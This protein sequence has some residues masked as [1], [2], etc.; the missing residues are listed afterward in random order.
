MVY[1]QGGNFSTNGCNSSGLNASGLCNPHGIAFDPFGNLYIA[2]T[3]NNRVVEYIAPLAG[4]TAAARVFGQ[5]GDFT[6]SDCNFGGQTPDAYSLCSPTQV[7]LDS[8]GD[9]Y[10]AD[11]GN[12]RV[13]EYDIPVPTSTRTPTPTPA[14]S[15]TRA[16][17]RTA[18]HTPTR[19][20]T[21]TPT[22]TTTHTA[23][24]T[25]THTATRTPTLSRTPT[26][27]ATPK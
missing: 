13:T 9:V 21:H 22:R 14:D 6:I 19:T 8:T 20:A 26:P 1:G 4:N 3:G 16:A 2:D 12:N 15:P 25:P 17:T 18:T 24:T 27:T 11:S 5:A 23:T 7:A 10:I